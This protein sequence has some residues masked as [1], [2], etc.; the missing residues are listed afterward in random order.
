MGIQTVLFHTDPSRLE[1]AIDSLAQSVVN[2]RV[3]GRRVIGSLLLGDSSPSPVLTA[4]HLQRLQ[5]EF[6]GRLHIDY[7]YFGSNLGSAAGHNR[8]AAASDS[9]FV[10]TMNPD[11]VFAFDAIEN[12]LL[13]FVEPGTGMAE[14]KQ[15]PIEHPKEFDSITGRT[16]WATTAAAA[17][18]R[19]LFEELGGFDADT[20][21][22]YC[23]D[24]DF[25]WRVRMA[26]YNVLYQPSAVVMHDKR[27]DGDGLWVTT[28]AELYY[29]ALAGL[30]LTWKWSRDDLTRSYLEFFEAQ[31]E[32]HH[33]RAAAEFRRREEAEVLP[34][35][36]DSLHAIGVF[37][38]IYY[39]KHR[40]QL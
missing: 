10:V 2:A 6:S 40:F 38:G 31:G 27:L 4:G 32:P 20:F 13:A 14:A 25:S 15:I 21:F 11:V 26:G 5:H 34:E 37:E 33:K 22:L 29:S 1:Q 9:E 36:I 24:V 39:A 17:I 7:D 3:E 30:L 16:S 8:L 35:Q 18:W 12:L 19:P 23:D 28:E